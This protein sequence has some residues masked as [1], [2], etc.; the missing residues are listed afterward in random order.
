MRIQYTDEAAGRIEV[1]TSELGYYFCTRI[2]VHLYAILCG[3]DHTCIQ[4]LHETVFVLQIM[5]MTKLI[6]EHI[7]HNS[8]VDFSLC[9]WTYA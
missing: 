9:C 3:R 2:I 1:R 8:L 7:S 6:S 4:I 5:Y